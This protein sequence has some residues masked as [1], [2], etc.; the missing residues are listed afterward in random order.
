MHVYNV[1]RLS[2]NGTFTTYRGFVD[3]QMATTV[4]CKID[5]FMGTY[6]YFEIERGVA[7]SIFVTLKNYL[8]IEDVQM[9]LL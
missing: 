2:E 9:M 4:S 7:G 1:P 6:T 8:F 3:S 5:C